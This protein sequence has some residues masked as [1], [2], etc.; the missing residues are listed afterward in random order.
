MICCDRSIEVV[1]P[2]CNHAFCRQCLDEWTS[3]SKTCPMCRSTA[4]SNDSLWIMAEN[5]TPDQLFD[6]LSELLDKLRK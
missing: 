3:V 4:E 5:P 2:E 1:L 6:S